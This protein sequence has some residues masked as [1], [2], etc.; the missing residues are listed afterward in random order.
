MN[1]N[2]AKPYGPFVMSKQIGTSKVAELTDEQGHRIVISGLFATQI[3]Q[4]I[5][6]AVQ[7]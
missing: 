2:A 7:S 1:Q 5:I 3:A 6:K 4:A